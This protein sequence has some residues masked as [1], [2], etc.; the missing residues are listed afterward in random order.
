M[1]VEGQ[2]TCL[3]CGATS[4]AW[5]GPKGSPITAKGLRGGLPAGV[6]PEAPMRCLRCK[7]PVILEGAEP[8][9]NAARMRRIERMRAQIAE[10]E[11]RKRRAA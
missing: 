8:V 2:V 5:I 3:H 11:R 1:L 6:D 10:I 7:G 9:V 4:G